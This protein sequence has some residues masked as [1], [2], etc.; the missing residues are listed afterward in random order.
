MMR[1]KMSVE[2]IKTILRSFISDCKVTTVDT[3]VAESALNSAFKDFEDAMQYF[4][5]VGEGCNIIITR[6]IKDFAD[7]K[8]QVME[9][10]E[11]LASVAN[12]STASNQ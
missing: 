2:D 1:A 11:F 10:Q 3:N 12:N 5:A 9:P 6:N 8:I 7:A 4:S